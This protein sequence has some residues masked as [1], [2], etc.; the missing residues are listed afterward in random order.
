MLSVVPR[1][2]PAAHPARRRWSAVHWEESRDGLSRVVVWCVLS[3]AAGRCRRQ[4][5]MP[6]VRVVRWNREWNESAPKHNGVVWV[7]VV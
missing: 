7:R 2:H 4:I 1:A 5:A 6:A 3:A